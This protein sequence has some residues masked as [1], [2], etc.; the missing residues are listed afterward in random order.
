M[1]K[2][3]LVVGGDN[4]LANGKLSRLGQSLDVELRLSRS[5]SSAMSR[6]R[7]VT[8][9]STTGGL[10]KLEYMAARTALARSRNSAIGVATFGGMRAARFKE[11]M[12]VCCVAAHDQNKT[13][14]RTDIC[15]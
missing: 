11:P 12:Y 4:L 3:D 15:K 5:A 14:Q 13:R 8:F 6:S 9:A 10:G 2:T 1:G 7:P